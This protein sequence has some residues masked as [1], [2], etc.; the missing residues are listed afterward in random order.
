MVTFMPGEVSRSLKEVF[1]KE[2]PKHLIKR[3]ATKINTKYLSSGTCML[4]FAGLWRERAP[5][6]WTRAPGSAS[7]VLGLVLVSISKTGTFT[8]CGPASKCT[9]Q[10]WSHTLVSRD[11]GGATP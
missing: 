5:V 8:L 1:L 2:T 10:T 7:D 9:K 4:L 3:F 6:L 11:W